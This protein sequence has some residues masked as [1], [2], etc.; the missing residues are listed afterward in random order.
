MK[1]QLF[2]KL[3]PKELLFELLD[4]ICILNK[5]FYIVNKI[6]FKKAEFDNLLN[7]F[8]NSLK[9]YYFESKQ[10]Y[11][12]RKHNY[13]TFITIIRQICRHNEINYTF[14]SRSYY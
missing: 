8:F 11:L 2:K 12:S 5:N 14:F 6:S 13:N 4:K 7:P 9:E 3:Y 10:F 1:S